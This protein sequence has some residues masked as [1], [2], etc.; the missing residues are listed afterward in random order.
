MSASGT[1]AH[2]LRRRWR[3]KTQDPTRNIKALGHSTWYSH[4]QGVQASCG[5]STRCLWCGCTF[6]LRVRTTRKRIQIMIRQLLSVIAA[7][8][9]EC[10]R[11]AIVLCGRNEVWP[12][13]SL[14]KRGF[15]PLPLLLLLPSLPRPRPELSGRRLA[16]LLRCRVRCRPRLLASPCAFPSPERLSLC[17]SLSLSLLY[18]LSKTQV[19]CPGE[20]AT[21]SSPRR[22]HPS[23]CGHRGPRRVGPKKG[24]KFG[25]AENTE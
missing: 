9:M 23:R 20:L 3:A 4:D 11:V 17:L 1:A 7:T 19:G 16:A 22:G 14:A 10:S 2:G 12:T 24:A 18:F 15:E 13:Q 8:S 21:R 5:A 25:Q 6:V